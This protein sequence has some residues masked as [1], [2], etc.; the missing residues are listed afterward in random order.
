MANTVFMLCMSMYGLESLEYAD[1]NLRTSM[2]GV[3]LLAALGTG[4]A[5]LMSIIF[6]VYSLHAKDRAIITTGMNGTICLMFVTGFAASMFVPVLGV[7]L[8]VLGMASVAYVMHLNE[9]IAFAGDNFVIGCTV[10]REN[11]LLGAVAAL[12]GTFQAIWGMLWTLAQV[13]LHCQAQKDGLA[14]MEDSEWAQYAGKSI[15]L[16]LLLML[17]FVWG[18]QFLRSLC[19]ATAAAMFGKWWSNAQPSPL[20]GASNGPSLN[21]GA[22]ASINASPVMTR[23]MRNLNR[24]NQRVALVNSLKR[25]LTTDAGSLCAGA[26]LP[27]VRHRACKRLGKVCSM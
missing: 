5:V 16:W 6:V 15:T 12:G 10:L 24:Y 3:L 17:S 4:L 2:K 7:L 14:Q 8:L 23:G 21:G 20:P 22:A 18:Q 1:A 13:S 19:Y 11:L 26:L 27:A 25:M 9:H